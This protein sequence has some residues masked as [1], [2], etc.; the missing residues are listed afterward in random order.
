MEGG[1]VEKIDWHEALMDLIVRQIGVS[2]ICTDNI[3]VYSKSPG[4][5]ITSDLL[6]WRHADGMEDT[7]MDRSLRGI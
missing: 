7:L 3:F 2:R 4:F 5:V 1:G 6:E